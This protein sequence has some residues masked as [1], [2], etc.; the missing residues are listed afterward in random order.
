MVCEI[1]T[2][3]QLGTWEWV[4]G[5]FLGVVILVKRQISTWKKLGERVSSLGE[6]R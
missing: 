1:L 5:R 4:K 2:R 6:E 3:T